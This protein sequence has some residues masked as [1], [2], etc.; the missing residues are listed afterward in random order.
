M[1]PR[2]FFMALW[3]DSLESSWGELSQPIGPQS[4]R[5]GPWDHFSHWPQGPFLRPCGRILLNP[6]GGEAWWEVSQPIG[7]QGR[8]K[9]HWGHFSH[10][11]Q[12]LF[13]GLVARFSRIPLRGEKV[14]RPIGPHSR[15]KRPWGHF[16]HWPQGPFLWPC[17]P[18][19]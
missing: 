4:R 17:G 11:P 9:A 14:S 3:P 5:K 2:A 15:R 7:P 6:L 1:A 8:R 19:L 13:Y 10:W 16:S 18:I 12:G